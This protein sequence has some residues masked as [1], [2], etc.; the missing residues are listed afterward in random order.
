M[1]RLM[2]KE[3]KLHQDSKVCYICRKKV[4]KKLDK[5][6]IIIKLETIAILQVNVEMQHIVYVI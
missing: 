1:L 6:K 3:L 4:T 5:D 2:E